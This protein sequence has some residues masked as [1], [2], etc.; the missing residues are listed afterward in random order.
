MK[1]RRTH[2]SNMVF[3]LP[4]GT[5][6]NDLWT[7]QGA[8]TSG[9]VVTCSTWVPTDDERRAIADGANVEVILWSDEQ[10]PIDVRLGTDPIGAPSRPVTLDPGDAQ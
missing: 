10:P 3:R 9:H 2:F 4:G 6:D 8:D 7:Y 1:P 5:E